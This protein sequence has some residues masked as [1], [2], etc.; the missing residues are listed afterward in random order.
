MARKKEDEN[1]DQTDTTEEDEVIEDKKAEEKKTGKGEAVEDK[2]T[3]K[4]K[5]AKKE[6]KKEKKELKEKHTEKKK[7]D[8]KAEKKKDKKKDKEKVEEEGRRRRRMIRHGK[9]YELE[10]A[11]RSSDAVSI[12]WDTDE[13]TIKTTADQ[14]KLRILALESELNDLKRENMNLLNEIAHMKPDLDKKTEIIAK[15]DTRMEKFK[16]DFERYKM[17]ALKEKSKSLK[18][19]SEKLALHLL[20]VLDNMDRAIKET[21]QDANAEVVISAVKQ[22]NKQMNSILEKEGIKPIESLKKPFNPKYHEAIAKEQDDTIPDSTVL[23]EFQKGYMYKDKILRVAR[24]MVSHT[25]KIPALKIEEEEPPK[26]EES[27]RVKEE[28]RP[29]K[30]K[31]AKPGMEKKE[32]DKKEKKKPLKK[33]LKEKEAE[34]PKKPVDKKDKTLKKKKK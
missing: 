14:K 17:R 26:E 1:I 10:K 27:K 11:R 2:K 32:K 9:K 34:K 8:K 19:S 12:D 24:V 29:T 22:M 5:L 28:E 31:K 23:E 7:E 6:P 4:D 20:E 30:K 33:P 3:R 13:G 15:Y 25:D 18:Y 21:N 16:E